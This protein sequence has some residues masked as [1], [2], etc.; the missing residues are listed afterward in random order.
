MTN[1][2]KQK[3]ITTKTAL[4]TSVLATVL[5]ALTVTITTNKA[6]AESLFRANASYQINAPYTPPSFFTKP[7]VKHVGDILT[8]NIDETSQLDTDAE[9]K[10]TKTQV[11]NSNGSNMFN[12]MADF[13]L[14]K[15]PFG[16]GDIEKTVKAPSFDGLNNANNLQSKAESTRTTRL[17]DNITCQVV[18]ILPNGHLLVQGRKTVAVNRDRQDLYATG[19]VNPYFLNGNNQISSNMVANFQLI[20]TGKGTISRQ[21]TDGLANKV[22]QFF[23]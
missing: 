12:R 3:Y 14:D 19:I 9:L 11:V 4:T 15:L 17:V 1:N 7:D 5:L 10:I 22:Y 23:N 13:L 6:E 2:A 16:T 20:Q 21:Q 18:Q 8:I